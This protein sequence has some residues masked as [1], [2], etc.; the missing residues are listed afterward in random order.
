MSKAS[1]RQNIS[2]IENKDRVHD[3]AGAQDYPEMSAANLIKMRGMQAGR[4]LEG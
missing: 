2:D 3:S 4:P 1:E